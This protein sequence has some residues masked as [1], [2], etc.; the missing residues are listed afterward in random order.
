M[1]GY[2]V[3]CPGIIKLASFNEFDGHEIKFLETLGENSFKTQRLLEDTQQKAEELQA[4]EEEMRQ[5][6]EELQASQEEMLRQRG[7]LEA[8]VARL[9][10]KIEAYEFVTSNQP[11]GQ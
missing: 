11:N 8:E 2:L 5:N 9:Q 10:K 1:T 7:D 3:Y 6:Q 4:Q